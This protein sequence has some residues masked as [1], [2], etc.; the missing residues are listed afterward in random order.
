M[1]IIIKVNKKLYKG[2]KVQKTVF[3]EAR[4]IKKVTRFDAS[5]NTSINVK[6]LFNLE[7]GYGTPPTIEEIILLEN[8]YKNEIIKEYFI[9]IIQSGG[10]YNQ[11]PK[12]VEQSTDLEMYIALKPS[13]MYLSQI[14]TALSCSTAK[15]IV[16]S[17]VLR[18]YAIKELKLRLPP[19]GGIQ[20]LV[21]EKCYGISYKRFE[22][23]P[24]VVSYLKTKGVQ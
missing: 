15:A 4:Q 20:T 9:N 23:S 6:R 1:Y 7:N 5:D 2:A 11:M 22:D 16:A 17:K 24:E 8:Y 3:F 13:I 10:Y 19:S 21:F 14:A 12:R 18:D